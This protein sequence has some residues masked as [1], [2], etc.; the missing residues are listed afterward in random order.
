MQS[1]SP[2]IDFGAA[3][4][5]ATDQRGVTRPTGYGEDMGA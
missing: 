5:P 1:N 4:A 3:G 2:A